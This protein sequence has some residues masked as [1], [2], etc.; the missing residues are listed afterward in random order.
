MLIDPTHI[1]NRTQSTQPGEHQVVMV[2][3]MGPVLISHNN[4]VCTSGR[5]MMYNHAEL[6]E[7]T[8]KFSP[9]KRVGKGGFGVVYKGVLRHVLV[10]VKDVS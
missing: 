9:D 1:Q 7:A 4:C 3:G 10:A 6:E 5:V 2:E 8:D